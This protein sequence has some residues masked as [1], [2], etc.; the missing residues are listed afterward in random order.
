VVLAVGL[1]CT[2]SFDPKRLIPAIAGAGVDL[3]RVRKI[4]VRDGRLVAADDGGKELLSRPVRDFRSAALRGCDECADFAALGAD[5]VVGNLGSEPGQSTV[6][7]RTDAGMDAWVRAAGAFDETPLDDLE[8]VRSL[9][10]KNLS[11]ARR[12]LQREHDPEGSLWISY[13]E[14]L[15]DHEGTERAPVSP[16]RFRSHHYTVAC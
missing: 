16:P 1:F 5:I 12:T 7:V 13:E 10:A 3:R 14:H 11:R 9:A 8:P 2:R 15:A 4:D 6:L